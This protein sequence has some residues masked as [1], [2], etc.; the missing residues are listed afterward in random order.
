M[1]AGRSALREP[2]RLTVPAS[3]QTLPEN[4]ETSPIR[5]VTPSVIVFPIN[6][7]S[8]SKEEIMALPG[9]GEVLASRILAYR[10]EHGSFAEAAE[11]M[12]VEGI[13]EKRLEEMLDLI[14][15]GG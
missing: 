13:G 10:E 8:A 1:Y 14:T 15:T 9:V 2:L 3:M 12:N 5:E 7:N 4:S 11:L 6:I